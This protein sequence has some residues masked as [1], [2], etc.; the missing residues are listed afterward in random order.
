MI[1]LNYLF[2]KIGYLNKQ[3]SILYFANNESSTEFIKNTIKILCNNKKSIC[4]SD[5]ELI[6]SL[7][8]QFISDIYQYI[9]IKENEVYEVSF[10]ERDNRAVLNPIKLQNYDV[11]FFDKN[12]ELDELIFLNQIKPKLLMGELELC[13]YDYYELWLSYRKI[14]DWIYLSVWTKEGR[15]EIVDWKKEEYEKELSIILPIYNV[16]QYLEKC[17]DNLTKWEADYIEII[18]VND[19]SSDNSL[20]ILE[21]LASNDNRIRIINKPNGGC[22]SAR[23]KGQEVAKGRFIGFVDPDDFTTPDMFYLLHKRALLGNYDVTYC[24]YNEYYETT[25]KHMPLISDGLYYPYNLGTRDPKEIRKLVINSRIA[26]WRGIYKADFLKRESITFNEN[27]KRFDDLPFKFE[28]MAKAKSVVSIIDFMYYYRLQR[29]GQDVASDDDRLYI[30]FDIFKYLDELVDKINEDDV[31]DLLQIVKIDTHLW[32]LSKIQK[33]Y[34]R[35]Y[36]KRTKKDLRHNMSVFRTALVAWRYRGRKFMLK[37]LL[38]N[39][40]LINH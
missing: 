19:G 22:A 34:R 29:P 15:N 31:R 33:K 39:L 20:Q 36:K 6:E 2:D 3:D 14:S 30:H 16:E 28:I 37:S 5:L 26:I 12:A 10:D 8:R 17:I 4:S 7:H 11:L 27:F 38:L 18:A 23:K 24:G 32:A 21:R 13:N 9:L 40:G 1:R 25:K 35:E